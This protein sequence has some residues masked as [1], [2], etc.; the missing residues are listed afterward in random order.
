VTFVSNSIL[1]VPQSFGCSA[2]PNRWFKFK[3]RSQ[4]FIRA[5]NETVSVAAVRVHN[6][7]RLPFFRT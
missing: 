1:R 5:H 7:D 3:K 2:G 6:P 4:L